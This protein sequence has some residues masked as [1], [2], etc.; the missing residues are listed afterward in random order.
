MRPGF[1]VLCS[2]P[3]GI[4]VDWFSVSRNCLPLT[5]TAGAGENDPVL[6]AVVVHL[7]REGA[8]RFHG[9][10]VDVEARGL[11]HH[12]AAA[13]WTVNLA[14]ALV[15]AALVLLEELDRLLHVTGTLAVHHQH[16]VLG[17]D[18]HQIL[19]AD[20]RHQLL[21]AVDVAVFAVVHP[22]VAAEDVT[23]LI[24]RADL[25]QGG[26]EPTSLQSA[27][28]PTTTASAVFSITA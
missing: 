20:G 9:D 5:V 15:L 13:L 6:G 14:V 22:R 10:A 21:V 26:P 28:R 1:S 16:G 7:H 24:F 3:I 19:H 25:P 23:L 18:N 11:D 8:A 17:A 12:V 2:A 27:S 4:K